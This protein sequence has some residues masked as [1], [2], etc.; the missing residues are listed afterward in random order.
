LIAAALYTF[1]GW[2]VLILWRDLRAHTV[3]ITLNKAPRLGL[4]FTA[5]GSAPVRYF[6]N[7]PVTI[8]RDVVCDCPIED[9]TVSTRH[10]RLSFHHTQWWLDDLG[11]TNGT[12]LNGELVTEAVVLTSGDLIRCGQVELSVEIQSLASV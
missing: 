11:S 12:M 6:T 1:L 8:G 3:Q 9:R 4:R 5:D 2:V 7:S 10:A